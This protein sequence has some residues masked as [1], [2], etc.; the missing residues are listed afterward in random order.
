MEIT[1]PA[2]VQAVFEWGLLDVPC[3]CMDMVIIEAYHKDPP[4][5][6]HTDEYKN[7]VFYY[8][9]SYYKDKYKNHD[10]Y[11]FPHGFPFEDHK[12][13]DEE[14]DVD[15]PG[16]TKSWKSKNCND[17]SQGDGGPVYASIWFLST[18]SE[19]Y[20][21]KITFESHLNKVLILHKCIVPIKP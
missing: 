13:K 3:Q 2:G 18:E 17:K 5:K 6:P 20:K 9:N 12:D 1:V 19:E 21:L 4:N 11:N 8:D 7:N 15:K 10:N 14:K 16:Y